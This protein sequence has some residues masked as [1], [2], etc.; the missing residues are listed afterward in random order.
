MTWKPHVTVAAVIHRSGRFLLVEEAPEGRRV[1][2]QPAGHLEAGEG[3]VDAVVR[4]V[5]EETGR[6]FEPHGLV[7]VYRHVPPGSGRTYLRFCFAGSAGEPVPGHRLDPDILGLRWESREALARPGAPL[8]SPL[9]LAAVD[10]FLA[11]RSFPLDLLRDLPSP[12]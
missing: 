5:L 2:N 7:G 12:P 11:G 10:D 4:E 8:R 9:V 1:W 3:L 6:P